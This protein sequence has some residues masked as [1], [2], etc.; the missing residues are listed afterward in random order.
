L[1]PYP[2]EYHRATTL[3]DASRLL[4]ELGEEA[5]V[6]AGGQSLIPLMKLRLARPAFL[7]D[8]N[9]IPRAAYIEQQNGHLRIGAMTRHS[10][11]EDSP[12]AARIP[13]LHDCAA[14]IA[15]AQVRN[16]GTLGGS[17]AEA[18]PHGDWA[19]VLLALG[20]EVECVGPAGARTVPM[21]QFITDAFTTVLGPAELVR[22]IRVP[23]PPPRSAGAYIAFKRC[24]PV[25]P[26]ASAAVQVTMVDDDFCRHAHIA[27]GCVGLMPIVAKEAEA[28][29]FEQAI[30]PLSIERAADAAMAAADPQPDLRGSVDYKRLLVRALMRR[31]LFAALARARGETVEVL[32]EYAGR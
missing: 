22:E 20:A 10:T 31:A 29:L 13:I 27:L 5:K 4:S 18:D 7:V 16:M 21:S 12:L 8:L 26:T 32:H 17:V 24:A 11:I 1:I 2:F 25:Y 19:P 28:A 30:T 14:G 9:H 15:D 23:A 3:E 6:L